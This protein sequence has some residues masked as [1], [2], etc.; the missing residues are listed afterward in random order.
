MSKK[1]LKKKYYQTSSGAE[2]AKAF[3]HSLDQRMRARVFVQI[4]RLKSGNPGRGHGVGKVQELV[5]DAGPGYR[6]Y[7]TIVESG[8]VIL[9]LV[10]GDKK[11]QRADIKRAE[12]YLA[13]YYNQN[14]ETS[15]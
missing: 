6:V 10:A 7:Y 5:I 11:S 1:L 15:K 8:E 3:I 13:D 9:L 2:P 14:R 4:D 12:E